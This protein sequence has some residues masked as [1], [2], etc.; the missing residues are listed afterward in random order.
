MF[1]TLKKWRLLRAQKSSKHIGQYT[2]YQSIKKVL[3][4]FESDYNEKNEHYRKMVQPLVK[5]G[6]EV[7]TLGFL[8]KKKSESPVL[9]HHI[10]ITKKD[11]NF[12]GQPK[13]DIH[14]ELIN[15]EIDL[16]INLMPKSQ[17]TLEYVQLT[18]PNAFLW[19]GKS[20]ASFKYDF[21]IELSDEHAL[22]DSGL[23]N[24]SYKE[25]NYLFQQIIHYLQIIQPKET[26][27]I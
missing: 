19:T 18:F 10:I 12:W 26:K 2:G 22:L 5:D 11:I 15:K 16:I 9:D 17:I 7:Y 13:L 8:N 3:V 20:G 21:V 25:S 27:T 14:K 24:Y 6:K 4:L 1:E 23:Q